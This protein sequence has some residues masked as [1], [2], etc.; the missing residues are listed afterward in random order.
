MKRLP[1]TTRIAPDAGPHK[2][3]RCLR[4]E[5]HGAAYLRHQGLFPVASFGDTVDQTA[6]IF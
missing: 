4:P 3:S 1:G 6:A 2:V 5:A